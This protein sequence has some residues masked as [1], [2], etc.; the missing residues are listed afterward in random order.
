MVIIKVHF[1]PLCQFMTCI[2][3]GTLPFV[4]MFHQIVFLWFC[5]IKH[6]F[7]FQ[8]KYSG[9]LFSIAFLF[10]RASP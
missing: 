6:N 8:F 5:F 1:I 2:S 4:D 7:V 9:A 3:A 10:Y